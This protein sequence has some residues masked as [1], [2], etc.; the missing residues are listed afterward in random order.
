MVTQPFRIERW[1]DGAADTLNGAVL[2]SDTTITLNSVADF[3]T[4]GD[5][6][7]RIVEGATTEY[8]VVKSVA[9]S[10]FT[11]TTGLSNGFSSGSAVDLVV[12]ADSIDAAFDQAYG[13]QDYPLNRILNEGVTAVASDF[14][15]LNQGTATCADA[16]D[17]GLIMTTP[18]EAYHQIRGKYLTA[19]STPWSVVSFC[20]FGPGFL[21]FAGAGTGSYMGLFCRESSTGKLYMLPIRGDV[22]ALWRMTNVTTFSADV[23]SFFYNDAGEIWMKLEDDGTNIRGHVSVDGTS[24]FEAWNEGRTSFMSGGP[25]QVG[26][27]ASSGNGAAGQ[28]F[29]FKSWILE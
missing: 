1:A 21:E 15:W 14:T 20:K 19:P 23:D 3:P 12:E 22:M 2:A 4:T 29:Y 5:F 10:V 17:G 18:S 28:H 16:D 24:W 27:A 8:A 25:D 26:F 6:T 7:V 13:A 11:L 9:G